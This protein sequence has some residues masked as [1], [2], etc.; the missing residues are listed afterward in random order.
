MWHYLRGEETVGPVSEGSLS[1]L[2]EDGTVQPDT[3]VWREGFADWQPAGD[4]ESL[5]ET[6]PAARPGL[7]LRGARQD[8]SR[9]EEEAREAITVADLRAPLTAMAEAENAIPE[10]NAFGWL[11]FLSPLELRF[12]LFTGVLAGLATAGLH[13]YNPLYLALPLLGQGLLCGLFAGLLFRVR[14]FQTGIWWGVGGMVIGITDFIY[15]F[16][17]WDRAKGPLL[18]GLASFGVLWAAFTLL[19]GAPLEVPTDWAP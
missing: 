16:L 11:F 19:A 18:L 5:V 10:A 17:H 1:T 12:F 15:P 2:I 6:F 9:T 13:F 14:T 8:F 7:A 3:Y 4:V